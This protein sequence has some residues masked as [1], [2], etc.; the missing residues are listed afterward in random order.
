[1]IMRT[2]VSSLAVLAA[3]G[4]AMFLSIFTLL[5]LA[6]A[7]LVAGFDANIWWIDLAFLPHPLG[8]ILLALAAVALLV[9]AIGL[10][11]RPM[12]RP[13]VA[14][15]IFALMLATLRNTAVFFNQWRLGRIHPGMSIPLSL[16]LALSLGFI[17]YLSRKPRKPADALHRFALAIAFTASL[18]LFPLAQMYCFGKTDYR[19]HADA[20][21]VFG[22][23]TYADG[24]LSPALSDRT[25]T[26]ISLY[27]QHLAPELIFSGGPGD[28]PTSEPQAM[29]NLAI[30]L[31]VPASAILLDEHG[32]NTEST[33]ANT[34][35]IF[36][37]QH[38][39]TVLAVSHF[40]HLPRVKMAYARALSADHSGLEVL[41][42]PA[43]ESA[44]LPRMPFYM[45]REIAALWAYYLR[46]LV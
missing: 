39:K 28:G 13:L 35:P 36:N 24:T 22:A 33:V 6:G 25:R 41:T 27:Q 29:K 11:D 34:L 23:R 37:Q 38:L 7:R 2:F 18:F 43:E 15:A 4:L 21:V 19:R 20:I 9:F 17:F 40:Y 12:I 42:V 10:S 1:M 31:G 46:P 5:N 8:N 30:S 32:V 26:A 45:T 14:I 44:P 3:R 16:F